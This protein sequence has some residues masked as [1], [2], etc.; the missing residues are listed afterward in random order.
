M[1]EGIEEAESKWRKN[2]LAT[3]R[4][5]AQPSSALATRE[6][7]AEEASIFAWRW[8]GWRCGRKTLSDAQWARIER[9]RATDPHAW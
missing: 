1:L 6:N 8:Q 7:A 5:A 9:L 2:R 3:T 4:S